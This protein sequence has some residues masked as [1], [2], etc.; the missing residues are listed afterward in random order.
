MEAQE[1]GFGVQAGFA[2]FAV[3]VRE[4]LI[5]RWVGE[6]WRWRLSGGWRRRRRSRGVFLVDKGFRTFWSCGVSVFVSPRFICNLDRE[7][8]RDCVV[9]FLRAVVD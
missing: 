5:V 7:T 9:S 6:I 2:A 8:W 1:L 3:T 4:S